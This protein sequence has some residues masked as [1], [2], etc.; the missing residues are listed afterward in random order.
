MSHSDMP[1]IGLGT[2]LNDDPE[3]CRKSV[4]TA[5][6][7][8]YRMIDTA[9]MYGNETYVGEGIKRADVPREEVFVATKIAPENNEYEEVLASA[10]ESLDQLGLD[11]LELL[12]LHWPTDT[13]D[14][15][16]LQALNELYEERVVENVG[17]SNFTPELLDDARESLDAPVYAHQVEL[18]PLLQQEN[19]LAYAQEHDHYLVAYS[20]LAK[21]AVFDD[22]DFVAIADK[23]DLSPAALSLAWLASK[24]NVVPIPKSESESHQR[25]NLDALSIDLDDEIVRRIDDLEKH[26]RIIDPIDSI[27]D[28]QSLCWT[29]DAPDS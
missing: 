13:Y 26:E 23:C 14:K 28:D 25:D 8:G 3:T 22:A 4:R 11:T 15:G 29:P 17:L 16:T 2:A 9:Q 7:M 20:P 24:D 10:R 6:E 27:P 5:L 19:L 18:H 21:G 1:D 12:Y